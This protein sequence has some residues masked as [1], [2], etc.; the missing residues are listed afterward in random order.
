M[1]SDP[2][3]LSRPLSNIEQGTFNKIVFEENERE[4]AESDALTAHFMTLSADEIVEHVAKSDVLSYR[5]VLRA[6]HFC[7]LVARKALWDKNEERMNK[8]TDAVK[9][10]DIILRNMRSS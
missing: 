5:L 1:E 2:I 3:K 4:T 10:L 6:I 8:Y 9:S 7:D